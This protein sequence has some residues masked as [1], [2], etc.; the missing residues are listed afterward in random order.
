[1]RPRSSFPFALPR[2]GLFPSPGAGESGELSRSPF[3]LVSPGDW[4]GVSW[5]PLPRRPNGARAGWARRLHGLLPE[6]VIFAIELALARE[7][8]L[9][10]VG[11]ALAALNAFDVP[12]AVQ[13]VQ[14]KAVE[15]GPLA[16]G[17][18]HHHSP[19]PRRPGPPCPPFGAP[20]LG[21]RA[22]R[23]APPLLWAA[24]GRVRSGPR[25]SRSSPWVMTGLALGRPGWG[26][27]WWRSQ[28]HAPGCA[29][30]RWLRAPPGV[31]GG[32]WPRP[33]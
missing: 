29:P 31:L 5:F 28:P 21:P 6:E 7:A 16:T 25:L 10:E 3:E 24:A 13:H 2:V 15:D 33:C 1:M 19:A 30:Q 23:C 26:G 32:C 9:R 12:R 27:E 14:Q 4:E 18:V 17:T 11:L 20:A 22:R 8:L